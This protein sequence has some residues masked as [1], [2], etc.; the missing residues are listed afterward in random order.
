[1]LA[2]ALLGLVIATVVAFGA[3]VA[4]QWR[5]E[6]PPATASAHSFDPGIVAKGAQLAAVGDCAVCHTRAGGKPYAGGFPVETPFGVVYG[7]NITP[8]RDTGIGAW[9]EEA[10]RRAMREGVARDGAHLYPAFPYDHFTRLTDGDISAL[11]AFLM[12]RE[13]VSQPDRPPELSFPLNWR[14]FAAAWQLL[15]LDKG[16]W[17]N[18]PAQSA[19]WN[20]GAYLVEG[21]GHCGACHTPRNRLGAEARDRRFAGGEGEGW[22]APALD[23]ASPAPV[24]WTADQLYNY[25]RRGFADQH[26]LAAGPMQPVVADLAR[27][28]EA[29][30]RAIATYV[31]TIIGPRDPAD[32]KRQTDAALAFA[33]QRAVTVGDVTRATTGAAPADTHS[34]G[35][36]LFDGACAT[37]HRSGGGLPVSRPV[38][39]AL[40]TPVNESDP[41]NL[42][43]IVLDG[44]HP[45]PGRRGPIMPAFSGMLTD[46]QIVALA[47]Y[48]RSR[49]SRGPAWPNVAA[50]L[51]GVRRA[52]TLREAP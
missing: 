29:D 12:T 18:D 28:P 14:I 7:T 1:M 43:R 4:W 10:F 52:Q 35:K 41:G 3:F 31:A 16:A 36:A 45:A 23:A 51:A 26:G 33:Q 17:R 19:Q 40:S 30:V 25:L 48:V 22:S 42:L 32:R 50:A 46:Q 13:Q 34:A 21:V 6:L 9:S 8:D 47:D 27:A 20:R 11:Y 37:C 38:P 15:F 49:Y 44:I 24:P 2:R 39:L 5:G